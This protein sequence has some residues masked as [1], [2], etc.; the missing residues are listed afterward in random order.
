MNATLFKEQSSHRVVHNIYYSV[1]SHVKA[2]F[3]FLMLV[4]VFLG[5]GGNSYNNSDNR[6]EIETF[7]LKSNANFVTYKF[8]LFDGFRTN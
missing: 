1:T 7:L 6:I 4:P 3:E 5:G 2:G 8:T